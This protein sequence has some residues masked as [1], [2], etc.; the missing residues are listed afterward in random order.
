[1]SDNI[2]VRKLLKNDNNYID[3]ITNWMYEWWGKE[4]GYSIN[5]TRCFIEHSTC[6]DRIPQIYIVLM[7]NTLVGMYQF[8]NCDLECRPDIYPWL[9]NVYVDKK[10]RNN[11]ICDKMLKTVKENA[12]N[13]RY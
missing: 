10:Y 11:G 13:I 4:D 7:D 12:K 9:C 8:D 5:E 2:E 1:M 6:N 3:K